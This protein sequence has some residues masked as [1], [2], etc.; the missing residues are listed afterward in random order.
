M[1][2]GKATLL[3]E[4]WARYARTATALG[5][6]FLTV[7]FF[8]LTSAAAMDEV[9]RASVAADESTPPEKDSKKTSP[10]VDSIKQAKDTKARPELKEL[11]Q[12]HGAPPETEIVETVEKPKKKGPRHLLV[13]LGPARS[14]VYLNGRLVGKTPYGGQHVCAEGEEVVIE[15]LPPKGAPLRRTASCSGETISARE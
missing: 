14:D 2:L 10:L 8:W 13:D 5:C 7:R 15:V 1:M 6:V 4:R 12:L 3:F 9:K 11:K